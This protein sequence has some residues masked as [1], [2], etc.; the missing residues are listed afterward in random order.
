MIYKSIADRLRLRLNSS[1]FNIGSP[2]PGEK[3]LAEEF[4]VARMTIRKAIELL[5]SWGLVVRRHGSGTFVARKDVHHETTNL[6]GLAEVLRKQG[7]EVVSEVLIFEVMPAP[8]AIA[9][10]LRIQINE[11]IYFSRRVR[12]V[13]GKP[14]MLEDSYMPVK[15]FRNLSLVHLEGSKFDY[16]EKECGITIS[17]NYESLTPV[18]VDKQLARS[19]N[20]PEQTP[21]LRITSLSYSDS[22]EFLNYSVMFRNASEYQVDY[23]LRRVHLET[24]LTHPPEQHGQ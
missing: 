2:L 21:L 5:I 13:D 12:Y 6:T 16:I 15:L 4:G 24:P 7:K 18:L 20:V 17:G 1:D 11:R 14:L 8:P 9:S 3:K 23:H 10:Q 19:M 22:G